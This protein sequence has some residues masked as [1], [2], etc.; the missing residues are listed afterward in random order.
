MLSDQVDYP[1]MSKRHSQTVEVSRTSIAPHGFEYP[2]SFKSILMSALTVEL[3]LTRF[4]ICIGLLPLLDCHIRCIR[5]TICL[6]RI[7]LAD[8]R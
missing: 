1:R 3:A 2:F 6:P 4:Q 8:R 5:H 7:A